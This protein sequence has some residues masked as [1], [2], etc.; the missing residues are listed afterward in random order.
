VFLHVLATSAW[1]GAA[2]WVPGD[3]R[4]T[5]ARGRADADG[6]PARVG[7]ALGLDAL[8][9]IASVLTGFL[10]LWE[11]GMARPPF[12]ISAGIALTF[13]RLLALAALRSAVRRV[14]GRLRAGEAVAADD[15]AARRIATW[16]GIAHTAWLLALAGMV[17]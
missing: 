13:A 6:L 3:V 17:G 1:L 12:G 16:S 2:L 7:P 15:P 10:L 11:M 4:R 14:L 8:A 5:L 9:G